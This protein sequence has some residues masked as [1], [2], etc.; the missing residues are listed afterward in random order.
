MRRRRKLGGRSGPRSEKRR[1]RRSANERE[2]KRLGEMR[3]NVVRRKRRRSARKNAESA[4]SA[5][6]RTAKS[7]KRRRR[8]V[9]AWTG[10]ERSENARNCAYAESG[11][12]RSSKLK[13]KHGERSGS[14]NGNPTETG[15]AA[16]TAIVAEIVVILGV[17]AGRLLGAEIVTDVGRGREVRS[18]SS[19]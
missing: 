15:I 11:K 9:A 16:V 14:A 12:M 3:G 8:N 18:R 5:G 17:G 4:R 1:W 10:S 7:A 6:E 2:K 13:G 19:R